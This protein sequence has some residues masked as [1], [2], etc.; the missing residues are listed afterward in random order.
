VSGLHGCIGDR[1]AETGE[2]KLAARKQVGGS[3]GI[4]QATLRNW[5]E[6]RHFTTRRVVA[7][8][9]EDPTVEAVRQHPL[10]SWQRIQLC[11]S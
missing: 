5:I 6:G 1:I 7:D 3:L 10:C 9:P 2:S 11:L 4:N 8:A